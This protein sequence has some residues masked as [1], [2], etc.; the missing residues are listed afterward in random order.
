MNSIASNILK[1]MEPVYPGDIEFTGGA[2]KKP[3]MIRVACR[4]CTQIDKAELHEA[5]E[6]L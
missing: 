2:R 5:L 4:C 3:P 6:E 1:S